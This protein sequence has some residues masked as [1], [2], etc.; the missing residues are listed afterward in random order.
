MANYHIVK[1][2]TNDVIQVANNINRFPKDVKI[3]RAGLAVDD[4]GTYFVDIDYEIDSIEFNIT[5][6]VF[7]DLSGAINTALG[8]IF[9]FYIKIHEPNLNDLNQLS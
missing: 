5:R 7:N 3:I 1:D 2:L 6:R 8:D 9:E 4:W